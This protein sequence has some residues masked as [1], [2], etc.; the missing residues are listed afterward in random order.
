MSRTLNTPVKSALHRNHDRADCA[1]TS[2]IVK[3]ASESLFLIFMKDKLLC[4]RNAWL[5]RNVCVVSSNELAQFSNV[6]RST[7]LANSQGT[8]ILADTHQ[9]LSITPR[10]GKAV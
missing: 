6:T 1:A 3:L 5:Q 2:C 9:F 7:R 10:F 8:A 4:S